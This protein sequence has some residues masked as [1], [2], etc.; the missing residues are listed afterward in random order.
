MSLLIDSCEPKSLGDIT[1]NTE[2][3]QFLAALAKSKH[4]PHI[5]IQGARGAGKKL[6]IRLFLK[7]KYGVFDTSPTTMHFKIQGKTE[8][9]SCMNL[10]ASSY[11]YQFNP[12]NHNTY[13]RTLL[14]L[15]LNEISYSIISKKIAYRIIIIEDADM[16][17]VEA[18]EAL[19]RTLET[20]ITHCRFIFISNNEGKIIDPI[21]S[22]C[23]ILR[24]NSPTDKEMTQILQSI[25]PS[26]DAEIAIQQIVANSGRNI[27]TAINYL[28]MYQAQK[29][30]PVQKEEKDRD[31]KT[32][33]G[34]KSTKEA[35]LITNS[36]WEPINPVMKSCEEIVNVI[37]KG[38]DLTSTVDKIREIIYSLVNYCVDHRVILEHLLEQVLK[39]IPKQY[40]R[41]K[42]LICLKA[43]E[44]DVSLRRSSKGIYHLEGFC[45]YAMYII[46]EIMSQ[47]KKKVVVKHR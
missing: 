2:V 7:E 46:K 18:Q 42:Y 26:A 14:K 35:P 43:S 32:K 13:D 41:E 4:M 22:R 31:T 3:C 30:S 25:D 10:L 34:A 1:H 37:V 29:A 17:T 12:Q 21:M 9:K 19:R 23:T 24:V 45:L 6:M 28:E 5:L 44:R 47:Q 36:P 15:F 39:R 11:H 20:H 33:K 40:H 38:T 8:D 16:L 27:H